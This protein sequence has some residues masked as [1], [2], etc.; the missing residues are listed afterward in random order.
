MPAFSEIILQLLLPPPPLLFFRV[1]M[2]D[3]LIAYVNGKRYGL[4]KHSAE[5][6]L[7][8]YLRSLGLTGT[9]LGCGE[10]G[11]GACTVMLS[12]WSASASAPVHRAVN[13]CTTPVYA[14]DGCAITTVE[15]IGS[16]RAGLH[17]IQARLASS[18]AA[19]AASARLDSL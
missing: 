4:P 15:G 11:C 3:E 19:S 5:Q 7:L 12:S 17:P 1:D 9:K 2:D 16:L 18:M 8:Q 13:A 6:S 14:I 10:G